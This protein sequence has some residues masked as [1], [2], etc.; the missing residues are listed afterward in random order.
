[1]RNCPKCRIECSDAAT[2]CISCGASLTRGPGGTTRIGR[3]EAAS[4]VVASDGLSRPVVWGLAAGAAVLAALLWVGISRMLDMRLSFLVIGIAIAVGCAIGYALDERREPLD[5]LV[6]VI[7]TV[8]GLLLAKAVLTS[9]QFADIRRTVIAEVRSEDAMIMRLA[10][11]RAMHAAEEVDDETAVGDTHGFPAAVWVAARDDWRAM[12]PAQQEGMRKAA[13]QEAM[14]NMA[15][16][17]GAWLGL[18]TFF[19]S[20][21]GL[22]STAIAIGIAWTLGSGVNRKQ[23]VPGQVATAR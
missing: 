15:E 1:M 10:E 6:A 19:R 9:L 8:L 17:E 5:G 12:S 4:Q 2:R 3:P 16:I 7:L 11:D 21:T 23:A 20:L 18:G 22:G 14:D 13:V